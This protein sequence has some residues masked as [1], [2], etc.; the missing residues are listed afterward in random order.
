MIKMPQGK[1]SLATHSLRLEVKYL[2][3]F[4]KSC[5][6]QGSLLTSRHTLPSKPRF[7]HGFNK[8]GSM[9]DAVVAWTR[10]CRAGVQLKATYPRKMV[11]EFSENSGVIAMENV[12]N[13]VKREFQMIKKLCS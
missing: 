13:A 4:M 7:E 8:T 2:P 10:G 1:T 12:I 9:A 3:P 6:R 11:S 5:A